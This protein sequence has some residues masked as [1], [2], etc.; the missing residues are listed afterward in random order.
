MCAHMHVARVDERFPG[1]ERMNQLLQT[2]DRAMFIKKLSTTTMYI[3]RVEI[4][5]NT[6]IYPDGELSSC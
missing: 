5:K 4:I 3:R 2:R 1:G 6:E